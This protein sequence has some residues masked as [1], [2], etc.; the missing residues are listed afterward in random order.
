MFVKFYF[1]FCSGMLINTVPYDSL[2]YIDFNLFKFL[3]L[4]P[5]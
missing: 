4:R 1:F 5:L 2:M 3:I